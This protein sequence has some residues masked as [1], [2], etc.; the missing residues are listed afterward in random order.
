M[1]R[2]GEGG[3]GKEKLRKGKGVNPVPDPVWV[4]NDPKV[5]PVVHYVSVWT[6]L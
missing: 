2:V 3:K 1:S 5:L 6:L 4:G